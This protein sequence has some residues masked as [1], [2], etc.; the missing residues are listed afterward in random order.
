MRMLKLNGFK[1]I[2]IL[3]IVIAFIFIARCFGAC[4]KY[5]L[6]ATNMNKCFEGGGLI[7]PTE[8]SV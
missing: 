1:S 8:V 7:F 2:L 5:S 4:E 6:D 3:E